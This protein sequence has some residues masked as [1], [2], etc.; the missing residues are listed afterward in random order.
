[1]NNKVCFRC[2][3]II[4]TKR[5]CSS[6]KGAYVDYC[7][8]SDNSIN[9][10]IYKKF[11]K[12]CMSILAAYQTNDL[13]EITEE[14]EKIIWTVRKILA[15]MIHTHKELYLEIFKDNPLFLPIINKAIEVWNQFEIEYSKLNSNKY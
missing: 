12:V 14:N 10:E 7:E 6:F 9:I 1:M 11:N 13:V 8:T 2:N 5:F 15:S 3:E 4:D